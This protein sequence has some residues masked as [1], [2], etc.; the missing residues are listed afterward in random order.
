LYR[1]IN[2]LWEHTASIFRAE[3]EDREDVAVI[4]T[5]TAVKISDII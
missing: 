5:A 3:E 1:T 4:F 2:V